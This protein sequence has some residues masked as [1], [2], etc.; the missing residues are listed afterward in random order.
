MKIHVLTARPRL[1]LM[2]IEN[3]A[4]Y[5][6]KSLKFLLLVSKISHYINCNTLEIFP[7]IEMKDAYGLCLQEVSSDPGLW[8]DNMD[9]NTS[10]HRILVCVVEMVKGYTF[11]C[12]VKR[13]V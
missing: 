3:N 9:L 4:R 11:P 6:L 5:I 12:Q 7:L 8:E 13:N 10:N 2:I 1:L